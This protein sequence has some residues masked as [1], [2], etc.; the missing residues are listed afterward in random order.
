MNIIENLK[1]SIGE[2]VE[3]ALLKG[4]QCGDIPAPDSEIAAKDL[5][6]LEI[7][8]DKQHGDFACNIAMMLA[9]PHRE[10]LPRESLLILKRVKILKRLKLPERALSTFI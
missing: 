1:A 5:M 8:K 7:P 10:K 2:A 4:I 6:K 9:K 3:K